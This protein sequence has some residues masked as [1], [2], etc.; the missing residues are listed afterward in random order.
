MAMACRALQECGSIHLG[1][2]YTKKTYL[3]LIPHAAFTADHYFAASLLFQLFGSHPPR[4]QNPSHK[5]EL[6]K[7]NR[8]NEQHAPETERYRQWMM[9]RACIS[10]APPP[11]GNLQAA[12]FRGVCGFG[13]RSHYTALLLDACQSDTSRTGGWITTFAD[14]I[15]PFILRVIILLLK[16]VKR[17]LIVLEERRA[18]FFFPSGSVSA[19][20]ITIALRYWHRYQHKGG[21]TVGWLAP[22]WFQRAKAAAAV[23]LQRQRPAHTCSDGFTQDQRRGHE[24]FAAPI[25]VYKIFGQMWI[26]S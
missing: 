10:R 22:S 1:T 14:Y 12:A 19:R 3:I 8:V 6:Q 24:K 5:I 11:F 18:H 13:D 21:L 16:N 9:M 20:W 4:A 25:I 7:K 15:G 17:A 23:W 2:R 26:N